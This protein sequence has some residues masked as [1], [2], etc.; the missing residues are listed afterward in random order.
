MG[1]AALSHTKSR[2]GPPENR[3]L[4]V[5]LATQS[6][7]KLLATYGTEDEDRTGFTVSKRKR[8]RDIRLATWNVRTLYRTGGARILTNE[9]KKL[10]V[11]VAAVQET[12]YNKDTQLF[13]TNGYNFYCSS[14]STA[15]VLGTAF[16]VAQ[17]W[18]KMVLNFIPIDERLCVLRIK[19]RFKNYSLI[20]AHAP[21]NE[22]SDDAK[23]EFYEKLSKAYDDCPSYDV[24]I[25][26]GD[27][28]AKVGREEIFR[29]TI[30]KCSLHKETN[31]NGLRLIDFSTEK[32]MVVKSTF[33]AHKKI[34][35]ATWESPDG[36]TNNQIDHFLIDGRHFSDVINVRTCRGANVDSDHFLVV[37]VL[38]AKISRAQCEKYKAARK[39]AINKLK[40]PEVANTFASNISTRVN[41]LPQQSDTHSW[42]HLNEII[43]SEAVNTLGYQTPN[44]SKTWFDNDCAKATEEKNEARVKKLTV[45]TRL[46]VEHYKTKR[47]EEKRLHRR[48]KREFQNRTLSELERLRNVNDT[49]KFYKEL[50]NQRRGFNPRIN[51]CR[52]LDGTLLTNKEDVL[53]RWREHFDAL[54]NSGDEVGDNSNYS[55][56]DD[57]GQPVAEPTRT[58]VSDAISSLKNNRS[59]GPDEIPAELIKSGGEELISIMHEMIV[60]IWNTELLPDEWL[61]GSLIPLHKKGDKLTCEN[62]RGISLLNAAYKVYAKIL[63]NRLTPHAETVIGEYQCGFRRDRSTSD[64]I[65]NLRLIL[66]RGREFNI[67]THHLFIDF[68]AAY[69][70]IIRSELYIAM[71]EL[72]FKTKLIRLVRATLEGF[73]S[74][75]KVQ[76]DFSTPITIKKGLKQGDA[77]S[78]L[79][80]NLALECAMRRAG[81]Q[82]SRTLATNVVQILGFA[83]DLDIASRTNAGVVETFTNL[84]TEAR[85]MGLVVNEDKTKYMKTGGATQED[86]VYIGGQRFAVVDSFVYLGALVRADGDISESIKARI[87]SANRCFYGLVRHLRSKL[88]TKETK[89]HIYKT[90]IRPV[91]L[92]GSET[93][94]LTRS[95]ENLLH[96][97]ERKVLR[98]IFGAKLDNGHYRRRYNFELERDFGE[99]NVVATVKTN[100][101]RWA[102]HMARMNEF[103]APKILFNKNPEGRR[104]V[105]RPKMRWEDGVQADLKALEIR[106]WQQTAQDRIRWKQIL[107]QAKF[108]HWT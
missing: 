29:P 41:Q 26:L 46:A 49:R 55:F 90:I 104:S 51:M 87:T 82:T 45:N 75:V 106:N 8:L 14:N 102:G 84:M 50:N 11:A 28:N 30:G 64:Q 23:E 36:K 95:D 63:Y 7:K 31:E 58:E 77:L 88:L 19:G 71:K 93:W 22:S 81:I 76:N 94:P 1:F 79:L 68:K 54:L 108:K 89:L 17:V 96:M 44:D 42:Q 2:L 32:G 3:G 13:N 85:R 67:Q 27:M 60:K 4:C 35:L 100:R 56:L 59:P 78:T 43:K 33:F 6:H 86:V 103:R 72:N 16:L 53:N 92:Y 18:N 15:H 48:K 34:H 80:F 57:D 99:P 5:G 24:K 62:Y 10:K 97:F 21:T 107:N 91:L 83:D 12:R 20:N 69:D 52:A 39:F 40:D 101:L 37:A 47:R 70:N 61:V 25:I 66:Q 73:K 98:T 65:F 74:Q 105:G 9:L 38:R